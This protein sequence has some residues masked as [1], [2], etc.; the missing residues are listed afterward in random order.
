NPFPVGSRLGNNIT[1]KREG[2]ADLPVDTVFVRKK[3]EL[4]D[5]VVST[6][7][8]NFDSV[9][10]DPGGTY[11]TIGG[12]SPDGEMSY[13][14]SY[15]AG[16]LIT[17]VKDSLFISSDP[18]ASIGKGKQKLRSSYVSVGLYKA[19]PSG[20]YERVGFTESTKVER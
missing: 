14:G 17:N 2:D 8:Y 3:A 15:G 19:I 11:M 4:P 12:A 7:T 20:G 9:N 13:G 16:K 5:G 1:F 6:S 10:L 18:D